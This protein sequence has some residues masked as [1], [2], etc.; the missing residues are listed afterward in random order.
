MHPQNYFSNLAFFILANKE[1]EDP[2]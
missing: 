2:N 1:A